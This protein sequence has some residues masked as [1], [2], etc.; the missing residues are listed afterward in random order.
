LDVV[1]KKLDATSTQIYITAK[2][3]HTFRTVANLQEGNIIHIQ[4][5]V[6]SYEPGWVGPSEV[7]V[8]T[9][10][11]NY[12]AYLRKEKDHFVPDALGRSFEGE[13]TL[14]DLEPIEELPLEDD[15]F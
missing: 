8:L 1:R 10:D 6:T 11:K 13:Y 4:Y 7:P 9:K 15:T 3:L 14:I 2:V 5:S 12:I